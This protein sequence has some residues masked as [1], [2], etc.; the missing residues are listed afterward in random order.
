MPKEKENNNLFSFINFID[1]IIK[2]NIDPIKIQETIENGWIDFIKLKL[3]NEN[4]KIRNNMAYII[5]KS[6]ETLIIY[7]ETKDLKR[8]FPK[9]H[10]KI[11]KE[12]L[13]LSFSLIFTYHTRLG[14]TAIAIIIYKNIIF[15]L[16]KEIILKKLTNIKEGDLLNI[17]EFEKSIGLEDKID[18]LRLGSFFIEIFSQFPTNVFERSYRNLDPLD[19][20]M[21]DF[22]QAI[23]IL[24]KNYLDILKKDLIIHP[25]SLPM[26]CPP[27]KWSDNNYGG[28]LNNKIERNEIITGLEHHNHEVNNKNKLYNAIN[29]LNSIKFK[30]NNQLLIFLENEGNILWSNFLETLVNKNDKL[31]AEFSL[32]IAKSYSKINLPIYINTFADWRGRI[33]TQ[34]FFIS[35]QGNDL[36]ASLLNFYEGE[37]LSKCGKSYFYIYGANTYNYKNI[38][39]SD[40]ETRIK[41]VQD[42]YEKIISLDLDFI[43]GA[44]SIFL[45]TAFSL[46]LKELHLNPDAKV[47]LPVFLD[48][49]C[50]GIQHL[51][52]M[53]QDYETGSKVNLIP[54]NDK[55]LVSDLY[56]NLLEPINNAIN[57]HGEEIINYSQ[58]KEIKLERK[59]IKL[60]IMTKVYNVSVIGIADQLRSIFTKIKKNNEIFYLI[61]TNNNNFVEV[62]YEDLYI[63]AKLIN[64]QIFKS[65]PS[66]NDVYNYFKEIINL[67]CKINI[68]VVWFT[69][70]GLKITQHYLRSKIHKVSIIFGKKSKT[71]VLRESSVKID[72]IKQVNAIIP[73]IIHSLDASHLINLINTLDDINFK[74]FI[75][76][77][78]CF[79]THPNDLEFLFYLIKKEFIL[80]YSTE[81][82]LN[83]F[84]DRLLQ[85]L[86]DHHYIINSD[87][88]DNKFVLI[89][90]KSFLIPNLPKLGKLDLEKIKDSKYMVT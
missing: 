59:H 48:A 23:L 38:A 3:D 42:N 31:Q 74:P 72:K 69:P 4:T 89:N 8:R 55:D 77:H 82:F 68:P 81:N 61:P 51:A 63:L 73:N 86:E 90:K 16:Y 60:P 13:I 49:T 64:D 75:C 15:N 6:F 52:A 76:V 35:Y 62:S 20:E 57:K 14:F 67:I 27:N 70:S 24:N 29:Y 40:Y 7:K 10:D 21:Y 30:I 71:V 22:D 17:N 85:N 25:T 58:F 84:H 2:L 44:E 18:K 19:T 78:D 34:S 36:S 41:W 54:Q 79:G 56:Y 9:I 39:K 12:H 65:L 66:L 26:L 43:M 28:F 46:A 11:K 37:K 32:N 5:N 1:D 87:E 50:S 33:Y 83:K 88:N 53:L 47:Y 45:F 80:L